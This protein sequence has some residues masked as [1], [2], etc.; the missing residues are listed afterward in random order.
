MKAIAFCSPGGH[1]GLRPSG[2]SGMPKRIRP[3]RSPRAIFP[4]SAFAGPVGDLLP[5]PLGNR[6]DHVEHHPAGRGAGVD[7]VVHGEEAA[8][9]LLAEE[10]IDQV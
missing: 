4:C 7:R 1:Q 8:A 5:F 2:A 3:H 10:L 9:G 6:H